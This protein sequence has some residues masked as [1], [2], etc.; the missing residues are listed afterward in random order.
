MEALGY[1]IFTLTENNSLVKYDIVF[2]HFKLVDNLDI[3]HSFMIFKLFTLFLFFLNFLT[4]LHITSFNESKFKT[5]LF[6]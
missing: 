1:G 6:M 3:L 4:F 5:K 2:F